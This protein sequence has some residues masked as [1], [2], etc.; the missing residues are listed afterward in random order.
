MTDKQKILEYLKYKGISKNKFYLKTGLSV[1][2]LDSGKSLG[3]DKLREIL[4]IYHDLNPAWFLPGDAPMLISDNE[5][6]EK[7]EQYIR[8]IDISDLIRK[9]E[10]LSVQLGAQINENKHLHETNQR[11]LAQIDDLKKSCSN[12]VQHGIED[13]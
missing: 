11:L 10:E 13:K 8:P 1:G 12:D 3:V 2:F 6:N 4:D 9:I 5:L 7:E